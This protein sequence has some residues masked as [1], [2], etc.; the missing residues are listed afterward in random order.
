MDGVYFDF[1][2]YFLMAIGL[3]RMMGL[4]FPP[5]FNNPYIS[6]SVTEFYVNDLMHRS[7]WP[8]R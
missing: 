6:R 7:F 5:N 4:T 1:S 8:E 3:G 2:G